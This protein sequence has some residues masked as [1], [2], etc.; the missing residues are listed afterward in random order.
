M[1]T[2]SDETAKKIKML[3]KI[4]KS[5]V[6][7]R[8]KCADQSSQSTRINSSTQVRHLEEEATHVI[9]IDDVTG[10]E[11]LWH[12]VSRAREEDMTCFKKLGQRNFSKACRRFWCLHRC[13]F[14]L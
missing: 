3:N 14:H 6:L 13:L 2:N 1:F 8:G 5:R 9:C 11:S 4:R 12:A 7:S 10:K